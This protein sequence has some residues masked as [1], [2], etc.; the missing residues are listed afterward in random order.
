[1]KLKTLR[2]KVRK[3]ESTVAAVAEGSWEKFFPVTS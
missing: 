1:M 3:G 2:V